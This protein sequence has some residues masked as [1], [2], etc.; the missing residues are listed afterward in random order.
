VVLVPVLVPVPVDVDVLAG[1]AADVAGKEPFPLPPEQAATRRQV[2]VQESRGTGRKILAASLFVMEIPGKWRG[3]WQDGGGASRA[4]HDRGETGV[5]AASNSYY[6][7]SKAA[8][9]AESRL[10]LR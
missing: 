1:V 3:A 5:T 4:R 10:K 8:E 2:R 9:R 6:F 7:P